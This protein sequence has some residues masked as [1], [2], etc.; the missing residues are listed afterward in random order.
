MRM[1]SKVQTGLL[2]LATIGIA[3]SSVSASAQHSPRQSGLAVHLVGEWTGQLEYRDYSSDERVF[4]PTWLTVSEAGDGRS[5]AFSY[6]YDDGPAKTVRE[7][8]TLTLDEATRKA[9]VV[10]HDETAGGKVTTSCYDVSGL[11]EFGKTGY[12][13]L[14][15]T[16][17]GRDD[18]KQVDVRIV[19]TLRRNLYSYRKEVRPAG[20]LDDKD[21]RFRDGYVFTRA[22]PPAAP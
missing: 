16:G 5:L 2:A 6:V 19:L 1:G 22:Q 18:E 21:F 9:T 3:L 14:R 4:L 13:V 11:E 8:V 20:S 10:D 7:H 17:R 12:G 15:L